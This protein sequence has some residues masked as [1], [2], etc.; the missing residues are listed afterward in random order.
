MNILSAPQQRNLDWFTIEHEPVTSVDLMNRA[1]SICS[2]EIIR[3]LLNS[4]IAKSLILLCGTGNNGGDGFVLLRYFKAV[5]IPVSCYLVPFGQM[6]EDCRVQYEL[7]ED[8]VLTWN[9][10]TTPEW[11]ENT[12]IID[13]ILGTGSNRTPE[14]ELK[15]AIEWV[16]SANCPVYAIDM[17]SGLPA[18]GLPVHSTIVQA[19]KAFTF[20]APKLTFF[21]PETAEYAGNWKVLDIGLMHNPSLEQSAYSLLQ[22]EDV[23]ALISVRKRFSHKG[24]Y[25]H[26]LLIAG[27]DGKMGACLLSAEATLRSGPGLLTVH[28]VTQGKF[29]LH[30]RIPEAMAHWDLNENELSGEA[31]PDLQGFSAVGIGP[32]LGM[33]S[34]VLKAVKAV[35]RSK[36]SCVIDA[37]ALNVLA[38]NPELLEELHENCVL[39]P[40]PKEFERLAGAFENSIDRLNLA[41]RFAQ[42]Y[43][44]T[45]VLK[46]AITAVVNSKG[47]VYFNTT[48]NPGMAKGGSGDT[49][50]GI[51]TGCLAQQIT[52]F[53]AARI[54][55]FHH[56][57][58]GDKARDEKGERAMLPGN[59]ITY[60]RIEKL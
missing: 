12:I 47:E 31:L 43:M 16:N 7:V 34:G 20:H 19:S 24:T 39:T 14:N 58:A 59:L 42:K 41:I 46:D 48:G 15:Q 49:L 55:V 38:Q 4:E 53:D 18:D 8:D 6:S 23:N 11:D 32:G 36:K 10:G 56:G 25:G 44:C 60:L 52:P 9:S 3:D 40:H 2:E 13:S 28:T 37:D 35:L 29:Q 54:A 17:P 22:K 50:T 33:G 57:L 27:S 21:L 51:I 26:A 45:L 30:Q 1:A 5:H